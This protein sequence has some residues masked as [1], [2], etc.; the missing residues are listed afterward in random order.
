VAFQ[1]P[2]C[3]TRDSLAISLA[4]QFPADSRSDDITFQL[5]DC[6]HCGFH[7]LA[8][9]EES[10]RGAW[11]SESWQH[12]GYW[13]APADLETVSAALKGCVQ[14]WDT[15]CR[16]PAH[17]EFGRHDSNGRWQGLQGLAIQG[18]FNMRLAS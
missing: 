3:K 16:C 18:K 13:I 15:A 17:T 12:T 6:S 1:C 4:M 14:P 7:G 10:R 8:V 5:V 11:D 2:Q 9:Y